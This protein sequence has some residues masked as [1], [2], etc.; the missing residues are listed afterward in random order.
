MHATHLPRRPPG[1]RRRGPD[2]Y[3]WDESRKAA[4]AGRSPATITSMTEAYLDFLRRSREW[5]VFLPPILASGAAAI[6]ISRGVRW[7][8]GKSVS[9]WIGIGIGSATIWCALL[10]LIVWV[11]IWWIDSM[12]RFR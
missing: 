5:V 12:E 4:P 3:P 7:S 9:H 6:Y 8:P 1:A 2:A 11:P 10:A